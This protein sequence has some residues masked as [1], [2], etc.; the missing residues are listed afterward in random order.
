MASFVGLR[1]LQTIPMLW[2]VATAV[3]LMLHVLPGDPVA[4]MLSE[5]A[6]SP[7]LVAQLRAQL[8]LDQPLHIQYLTYLGNVL[9]GDFGTSIYY[10]RAVT[11]L[12][13]EQLGATLQLAAAAMTLA[14]IIGFGLGSLAA[15]KHNSW[16]D[17]LCMLV[18]TL[19]ISM[20]SF[21]LSLLFI[22]LFSVALGWLPATGSQGVERLVM[23]ALVLALGSAAAI[24]RL[25]RSSLLEE[26]RNE[27][28]RTAYAK[29][30][31]AGAVLY[32]H[33]LRNAM[34]PVVTV[35]GLQFG[36][37]LGGTVI[38]ETIFARQGL[39]RLAI[40]AVLGKDLP[41]VEGTVIL[42]ALV[43]VLVNLMVDVTYGILDP[44]IKR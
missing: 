3:F 30:L 43:Y 9:R 36:F 6:A 15:A 19:G 7:A 40:Q 8:G 13:F 27:Y 20:P 39:G 18:A 11:Q 28:V 12:V 1:L 31:S 16:I 37:L 35:I 44:R 22:F 2:G 4:F 5:S 25:V 10:N 42:S 17:R 29:G 21:W 14:I 24:A 33:A 41:V 26:L 23:P 38:T 34:I 32:K